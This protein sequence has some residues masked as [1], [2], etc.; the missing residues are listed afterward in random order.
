MTIMR[1][2]VGRDEGSELG[3]IGWQALDLRGG[4]AGCY[5]PNHH[6]HDNYL[7]HHHH[8]HHQHHHHRHQ[9]HIIFHRG[10]LPSYTRED[11]DG[12]ATPKERPA[13]QEMEDMDTMVNNVML[14]MVMMMLLRY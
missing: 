13:P 11:G 3:L 14:I 12:M 6:Y 5:H 10:S 7:H 4:Q 2:G 8:H 9:H 1:T